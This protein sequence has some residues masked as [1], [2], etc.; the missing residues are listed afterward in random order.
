MKGI[1]INYEYCTGCHSCEVACRN[2]RGLQKGEFGIKL[3]EVG[4]YEYKTDIKADTP[5]EWV[6]NPTITKGCDMCVERVAMGKMASCVQACQAWCM[7]YGD[8]EELVKKMDGKTRWALYTTYDR[9]VLAGAEEEPVY[10]TDKS[11]L[12]AA[13]ATP[14]AAEAEPEVV[15]I[16]TDA[17]TIFNV[18][19]TNGEKFEAFI[20]ENATIDIEAAKAELQAQLVANSKATKFVL[21]ADK[22]KDGAEHEIPFQGIAMLYDNQGTQL[23]AGKAYLDR[24]QAVA[25]VDMTFIF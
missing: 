9:D 8:V 6:F 22:A 23:S 4:P 14:V 2:E 17:D 18:T 12:R 20:A 19:I 13:A 10:M 21:A 16:N 24:G 7:Y 15:P 25:R 5:Y 3:T 11:A 1:L